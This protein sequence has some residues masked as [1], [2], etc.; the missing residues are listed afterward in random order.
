MR[1]GLGSV[2]VIVAGLVFSAPASAS[3][4]SIFFDDSNFTE[5]TDVGVVNTSVANVTFTNAIVLTAFSSLNE[6]DFPPAS[7]FQVAANGH[8]ETGT[9]TIGGDMSLAFSAKVHKVTGLFTYNAPLL[10]TFSLFGG[11]VELVNSAFDSNLLGEGLHPSLEEIGFTSEIGII[12]VA[13][14]IPAFSVADDTVTGQFALDNLIF[15]DN[16][17]RQGDT[18]V[19]EPTTLLL[20]G[21]GAA[22]LIR[23]RRQAKLQA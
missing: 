10:L 1:L 11:G 4:V 21:G 12:G 3:T 2:L 18:A 23:R 20:V 7:D 17:T 6:A 8:D 13:V 22:A 5:L 14:S 16:F 19:P 15:D 9:P